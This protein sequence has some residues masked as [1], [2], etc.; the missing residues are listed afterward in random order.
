MTAVHSVL[1]AE[2]KA[3][4]AAAVL[5]KRLVEITGFKTGPPLTGGAGGK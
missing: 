3:P 2:K 4:E 5:E 1:S